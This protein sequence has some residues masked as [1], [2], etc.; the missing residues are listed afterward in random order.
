MLRELLRDFLG[1]D[2]QPLPPAPAT[3]S[4]YDLK[5]DAQVEKF[6]ENKQ[7]LTYFLVTA[8]VA[9]IAFIVNFTVSHPTPL[10]SMVIFASI[11]GLFT[12]GFSLL[13]LRF[14][15]RSYNLHLKYRY[16]KKTWDDLAP[17]EQ[18]QWDKLNRQ[19]TFF[20]ETAFLFLFI[21]ILFSVISLVMFLLQAP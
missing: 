10:P 4:E 21:E 9:V 7:K 3:P 12:S 8:S 14:E 19:A 5:I 15:H 6:V 20:I 1:I 16:Q 2:N 13:N 18:A 11:A 17:E